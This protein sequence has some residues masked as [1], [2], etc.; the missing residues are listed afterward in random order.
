M[1]HSV[2][3]DILDDVKETVHPKMTILP[4]L[5]CRVTQTIILHSKKKKKSCRFGITLGLV[6][7][8]VFSGLGELSVQ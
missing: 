6:N 8:D 4:P 2:Y 3:T 7:D 5:K 1:K